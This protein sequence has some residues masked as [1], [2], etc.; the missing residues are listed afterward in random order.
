MGPAAVER[1]RAADL[2]QWIKNF[3]SAMRDAKR[4]IAFADLALAKIRHFDQPGDPRTYAAWFTYATNCSPSQNATVERKIAL[5]GGISADELEKIYG[6]GP[7]DLIA[8][9][10]GLLAAG[11]A[12]QL[13]QVKAMVD[14][15]VGA[16][17]AYRAD[18]DK[19][20]QQLDGS[21]DPQ[22]VSRMVEALLRAARSM[23]AQNQTF[24][25][26]LQAARRHI[27]DF[28]EEAD[29]LRVDDVTDRLTSLAN[30]KDFDRQLDRCMAEA[31][32]KDLS[33]CLLLTDI[34]HLKN[35]NNAFGHLAGDEVLRLISHS[36]KQH[37]QPNDV[38]ARIG[39]DEFA[40]ILPAVPLHAALTVADHIRCRVMATHLMKR[41]TGESIGRLTMSGG[42]A[43]YRQGESP[44]AL[45]QRADRC[46]Q[47]AKRHG[48]NRV[49]CDS[50]G[51]AGTA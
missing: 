25:A 6:Y 3:G 16:M 20:T 45:M 46:L 27:S 41:T 24:T 5:N 43:V 23:E 44:W 36:H 19:L 31:E 22:G 26:R 40:V 34:D 2:L 32:A 7:A 17:A 10:I 47:A 14:A 38:A 33:L 35:V 11:V 28:Q 18:L 1:L 21:P 15:V 48:C 13:D 50:D 9:N 42:I 39:G 8:A 30:R 37:I 4:T 51:L 49:V 12:D 29:S